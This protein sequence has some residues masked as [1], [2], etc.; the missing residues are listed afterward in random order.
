M[1]SS[2]PGGTNPLWTFQI[3]GNLGEVGAACEMLVQSHDGGIELA[4]GAP[5]GVA[6]RL[7]C[8]GCA[9]GAAIASTWSGGTG[10]WLTPRSRRL[11]ACHACC[12]TPTASWSNRTANP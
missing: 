6:E 5:F 4:A 12:S 3:D 7:R 11:G 2:P 10:L 1:D 8:G 9:P